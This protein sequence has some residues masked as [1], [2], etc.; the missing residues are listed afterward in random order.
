[1]DDAA[2]FRDMAEGSGG[3]MQVR[4]A[5]ASSE[6]VAQIRERLFHGRL[7]PGEF[8]GT[9]RALAAEFGVSRLTMRDALRILEA[10]GIIEVKVGK[11]GGVRVAEPGPDR[12][13]DA[14]AI[15]LMLDG[16]SPA[17]IFEAQIAIEAQAVALAAE[18]AQR[19]DIDRLAGQLERVRAA[20][21]DDAGFVAESMEFH[22]LAV[23]A[24]HNRA[25]IAQFQALRHLSWRTIAQL[26]APGRTRTVIERHETLLRAIAGG[27]ADAAANTVAAHLRNVIGRLNAQRAAGATKQHTVQSMEKAD[28]HTGKK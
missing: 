19:D 24:S 20:V 4:P 1:M 25:L 23:R 12:F 2:D 13:A 14:L 6:I 5:K 18:R 8:I 9:E 26:H 22:M 27:D 11:A 7:V 15:Q 10:N 17:E 21:Q 3:W 16:V 28:A